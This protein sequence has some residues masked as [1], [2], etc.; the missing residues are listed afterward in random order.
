MTIPMVDLKQQYAALK[1]QLDE[2]IANCLASG[3]FILGPEGKALE[4]ELSH[5]LGTEYALGLASGTDALILALRAAG[6]KAGDEVITT[7]FT[8]MATAGAICLVGAKPVFVDIDPRTYNIDPQQIP[9]A[10]TSATRAI[11][12]VHLFGHPADMTAI[13]A[14]AAQYKLHIIED[15]AQAIGATWENKMTGTFGDFA[16]HSFFPSKNLGCYGDGG[17]VTTNRADFATT[18]SS[19]RNHGSHVRYHHDMLGY[20]SRLDELQ[21]VVLRTKLPFLTVYN[22]QRHQVAQWYKKHLQDL[23]LTLPYEHPAAKHV[24]HQYTVLSEKRDAITQALTTAG[25]G[26]AIYY[27]IPLHRQKLFGDQ[28][29]AVSLPISERVAQQCFSL[30]MFPEM[31]EE[32]VKQ[33]ANVIRDALK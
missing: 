14:I 12:P 27:P 11:I 33:V 5:Y 24:Y 9:A 19:L 16:C 7:P 20:N 3:H 23:P 4:Q 10:I 32:Q 21:A 28:Y 8:F 2:R 17:L 18:L 25:I 1:P 15:C 6:I 22:E 30:P 29:Q 31:T 26:N 13:T